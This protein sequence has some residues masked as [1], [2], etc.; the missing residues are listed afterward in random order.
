MK[1]N[2]FE[3]SVYISDASCA[4]VNKELHRLF[5]RIIDEAQ[6]TKLEVNLYVSGSLARKEPSIR[7]LNYQ[8]I[9]NSDIDFVMVY[10]EQSDVKQ[11]QEFKKSVTHMLRKYQNSSVFSISHEHLPN[12]KACFSNDLK[13]SLEYPLFES[14][15]INS[16]P[17]SIIDLSHYFEL[18]IHQIGG[19]YFHP[20][21]SLNQDVVYAREDIKYHYIK[22]I[23]ECLKGNIWAEN[24]GSVLYKDMLLEENQTKLQP[25]LGSVSVSDIIKSRELFGIHEPPDMDLTEFIEK[26]A[27]Y[28][29]NVPPNSEYLLDSLSK[30]TNQNNDLIHTFQYVILSYIIAGHQKNSNISLYN[31]LIIKLIKSMDERDF[32]SYQE[33]SSLTFDDLSDRKKTNQVFLAFRKEYYNK[34]YERNI[35]DDPFAIA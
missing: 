12:I 25:I 21:V 23:I 8:A 30:L 18:M 13:K 32:N 31:E 17:K 3:N 29:F 19:Y 4:E 26:V 5:S 22:M 11:L 24:N 20:T 34:L 16:L 15:K 9:L 6:A 33:L 35:G 27:C 10:N 2:F 7:V 14:F 28:Y 1:N